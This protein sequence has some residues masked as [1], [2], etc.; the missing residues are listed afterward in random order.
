MLYYISMLKQRDGF[1]DNGQI[2]TNSEFND[3]FMP[4]LAWGCKKISEC[5][6]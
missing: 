5:T 2:K 6:N 1:K 4:P 3:K